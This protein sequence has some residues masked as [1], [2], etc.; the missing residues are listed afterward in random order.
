MGIAIT[1]AAV[2]RRHIRTEECM[3]N[4]SGR[5]VIRDPALE[6]LTRSL[7]FMKWMVDMVCHGRFT[8]RA[9]DRGCVRGIRQWGTGDKDTHQ[10]HYPHQSHGISPSK[11]MTMI[12]SGQSAAVKKVVAL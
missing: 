12:A 5:G 4:L 1:I 8:S 3:Q 6:I 11:V 2:K 10:E 9:V 7:H